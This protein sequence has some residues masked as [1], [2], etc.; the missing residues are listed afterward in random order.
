MYIR[1]TFLGDIFTRFV[2]MHELC[3]SSSSKAA[4][5]HK[6]ELL[7]SEISYWQQN[8]IAVRNN[9]MDTGI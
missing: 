8:F 2:F 5:I 3:D 9:V 6:L 7:L 4:S 1:Y